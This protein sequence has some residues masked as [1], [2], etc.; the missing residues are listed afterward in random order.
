MFGLLFGGLIGAALMYFLEPAGG[1]RRRNVARD[2]ALKWSRRG[3]ARA[4][5][6]TGPQRGG[7][8]RVRQT[9]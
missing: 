5:A 1:A 3:A 2:R 8:K 6:R 4:G 7:G 9:A